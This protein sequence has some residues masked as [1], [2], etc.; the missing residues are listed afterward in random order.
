M[1]WTQEKYSTNATVKKATIKAFVASVALRVLRGWK[2]AYGWW[3]LSG[4]QCVEV[5]YCLHG[6]VFDLWSL[7]PTPKTLSHWL[8]TTS[9]KSATTTSSL[10]PVGRLFGDFFKELYLI[11]EEV[12]DLEFRTCYFQAAVRISPRVIC[13]QP[14]TSKLLTYA[15][16]GHRQ[17]S[18]LLSAGWKM[19]SGL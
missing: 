4:C 11:P 15:C 6:A 19:S 13:R 5:M 9:S 2:H 3:C 18:L 8:A 14:C 12:I 10:S 17:L 16:S 1:K 7:I